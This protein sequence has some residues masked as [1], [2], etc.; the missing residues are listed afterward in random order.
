MSMYYAD[1]DR[2][3]VELQVDNLHDWEKSSE[4]LR[5]SQEFA[6]NPIGVF[7]DFTAPTTR[8]RPAGPTRSCIAQRWVENS[9]LIPRRRLS[10]CHRLQLGP[11]LLPR[12]LS[13]PRRIHLMKDGKDPPRHPS[14]QVETKP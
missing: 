11:P 10:V 9:R 8:S 12:P 6:A 2:N 5:T 7:F 1:P 13:V 14:S 4:Y 3:M